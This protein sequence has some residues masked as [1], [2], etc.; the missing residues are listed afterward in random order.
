MSRYIVMQNA[1]VFSIS[2]RVVLFIYLS[3]LLDRLRLIQRESTASALP[4]VCF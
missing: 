2:F 1:L 4:S 3:L